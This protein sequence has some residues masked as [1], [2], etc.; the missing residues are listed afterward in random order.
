MFLPLDRKPDWKNPPFITISLI[1]INCLAYFIWQSNDFDYAN[2]AHNTYFY[3]F[4]G[5][6]RDKQTTLYEIEVEYY[7]QYRQAVL[8]ESAGQYQIPENNRQLYEEAQNMQLDA[9]FQALLRN[10]QIIKP[11]DEIYS[12]WRRQR[13]EYER[14]R[15]KQVGYRFGSKPD[16][17]TLLTSFTH[18]FL[19]ANFSHLFFNMLFLFLLGYVVEII[20]GHWIYLGAYLLAG[21]G[22]DLLFITIQSDQAIYGIGASGAI[23]GV[24]GMY[25]V[26]FGLRKIRFFFFLYFYFNYVR[27]PALLIA[28]FWLAY[29]LYQQFFT[30]SNINNL[31]HMG[32]F[33]TGLVI[34]LISRHLLKTLNTE[35]IDEKDNEEKYLTQ[36]TQAQQLL[37]E[38]NIDEARS[39]FEKLYAENPEDIRVQQQLFNIAKYNPASEEFHE[40]AH[41]LFNLPGSDQDTVKIL[42]DTFKDYSAKAQPKARLN[43]NL[44]M[45]LGMRFAACGY[46]AEAEQMILHVVNNARDFPQNAQG[47]AALAKY[48]NGKDKNKALHYQQML[49]A[50]F[51]D[52][53]EAR[54]LSQ[55]LQSH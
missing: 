3:S 55:A 46:L 43:A 26:L 4:V 21:L 20:L 14:A 47:L 30:D 32:G 37:A 52:S 12:V 15:N 18:M 17:P 38:M 28:P 44:L 31:A 33:I 53:D 13:N 10:N 39:A 49:M 2:E 7:R 6:N 48:Y 45:S 50:Q 41:K 16:Q 5:S 11:S 1:L 19:H 9:H 29:E 54:H 42:Y 51:P 27:A 34:A 36:Y 35:Y 25:V 8:K 40:Y 22:S 23:S 24:L